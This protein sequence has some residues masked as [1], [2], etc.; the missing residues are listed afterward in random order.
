MLTNISRSK[1]S[2]AWN[3][4]LLVTK[5]DDWKLHCLLEITEKLTTERASKRYLLSQKSSI[6][7]VGD[8]GKSLSAFVWKSVGWATIFFRRLKSRIQLFFSYFQKTVF[9]LMKINFAVIYILKSKL[10]PCLPLHQ[11]LFLIIMASKSV[12]CTRKIQNPKIV[13]SKTTS[14]VHYCSQI[15]RY[16]WRWFAD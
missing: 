12:G 6:L 11:K 9:Y 8:A 14:G 16:E 4:E 10:A 13:V 15:G 1:T 2:S 5:V 7:Y 3:I